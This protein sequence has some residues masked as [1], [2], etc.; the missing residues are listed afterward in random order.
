M[1]DKEVINEMSN[2]S[3]IS[4]GATIIGK[5]FEMASSGVISKLLD[6][7]YMP[8]QKANEFL[9]SQAI[10]NGRITDEDIEKASLIY[11][12]YR[13]RKQY[14]NVYKAKQ[15]ADSLIQGKEVDETA[16][17]D[18]D[19]F[20]TFED[21][22]AKISDESILD[23]WAAILAGEVLRNGTFR[24]IMLNRFSL[25]DQPSVKAFTALCHRTFVLNISDGRSYQIPFF[26]GETELS[27]MARFSVSRLTREEKSK[28]CEGLPNESELQILDEIGLI[29]LAEDFEDTDIL[30]KRNT[31]F[32][33]NI[34]ENTFVPFSLV[35]KETEYYHTL[36]NGSVVFT[37]IGLQLYDII[38]HQYPPDN[39][40]IAVIQKYNRYIEKASQLQSKSEKGQ[41]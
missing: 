37:S 38:G 9:S 26:I 22:V 21:Y 12:S 1:E 23:M 5:G 31:K 17:I 30:A 3:D 8:E 39:T 4:T 35:R 6:K 14:I 15:K 19:W 2:L 33:V 20:S 36:W 28:Y 16:S 25:L 40:L 32:S 29:S 41:I 18:E 13:L 7:K 27:E 11:G 10:K 24:K 34:G